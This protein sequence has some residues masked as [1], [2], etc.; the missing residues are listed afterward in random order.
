MGGDV[1]DC[2]SESSAGG[3]SVSQSQPVTDLLREEVVESGSLLDRVQLLEQEVCRLR[4]DLSSLNSKLAS[5]A[6][7]ARW[8]TK[9]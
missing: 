7:P 1:P 3:A 5:V 9:S 2:A 8:A 6:M 4:S